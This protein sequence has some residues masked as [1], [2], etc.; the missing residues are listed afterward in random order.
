MATAVVA[1][2][3]LAAVE[4]RRT[5]PA[6]QERVFE[7]WTEVAALSRWFAPSTDYET[8][9]HSLEART[10]GSYRIE[11]RH[12][13]GARHF[14]VGTYREVDPPRRLV[15]SWRWEADETMPDTQVTIDF[16]PKGEGTEVVLTHEHFSTEAQRE[17]H[18]K[19]WVGCLDRL[20]TAL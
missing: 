2:T 17:S 8:V 3:P 16:H 14:A 9:V 10:G 20:E 12:S 13:G 5:I 15:F 18:S 11:M 1:V 19:G 4:V 6:S 7:A